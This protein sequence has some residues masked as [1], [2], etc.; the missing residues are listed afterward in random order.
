M[1]QLNTPP[2]SAENTAGRQV[3]Y[4]AYALAVGDMGSRGG[5]PRR[6]W[7]G[8]L[9]PERD[10]TEQSGFRTARGQRNTDAACCLDE[11]ASNLQ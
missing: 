6:S 9:Q 4:A 2:P 10:E 5:T 11:A 8:R 1:F 3:K 7:P